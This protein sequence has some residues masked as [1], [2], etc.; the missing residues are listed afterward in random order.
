MYHKQLSHLNK[1]RMK[2][3]FFV[4]IIASF[5]CSCGQRETS[6]KY[7]SNGNIDKITTHS[8][9]N[10]KW[11][12]KIAEGR[13]NVYEFKPDSSFLFYS[14]EMED[15]LFG[16]YY[17]KGDTL[18]LDEKGSIYDNELPKDSNQRAERKMY[19]LSINGNKLR[20]LKM[21]NWINGRFEKSD[22]EFDSIYYYIKTE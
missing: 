21:S 19:W 8:L 7:I 14:C 10:T 15:S 4:I 20:H 16:N 11:E 22:F 6:K 13:I 1:K 17:F 5:F 9:A 2:Y 12:C 3:L 18:I